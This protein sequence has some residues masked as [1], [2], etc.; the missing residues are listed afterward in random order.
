MELYPQVIGVR[1]RWRWVVFF[2]RVWELRATGVRGQVRGPT[3]V[4]NEVNVFKGLGFPAMVLVHPGLFEEE[5]FW[6]AVNSVLVRR[7][8]T[9]VGK[10]RFWG[11]GGS[12]TEALFE[13]LVSLF[14]I[15][16]VLSCDL[17]DFSH[18]KLLCLKALGVSVGE[19]S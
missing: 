7:G 11:T 5:V 6:L 15:R 3:S 18:H 16:H 9:T 19:L 10:R 17:N 14:A 13:A 1:E 8:V 4:A 2:H 12:S